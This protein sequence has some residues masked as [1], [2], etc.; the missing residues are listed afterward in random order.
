VGTYG[1]EACKWIESNLKERGR[2]V[3]LRWWQRY[4]IYRQLEHRAD[5]SLCWK[6]VVESTPRRSGKST[7][8]RAVALWRLAQGERLFEPEQLVVHTGRDLAIVREVLRKAWPWA[9]AR[10]G[11]ATKRGMTEPEV[12][13]GQCRWIARSKDS[14]T[15]YDACLA[16]VD[17]A[18]DVK[19][20]TIDDDLEPSMLE[21]E[22][23]QL[24]LTS[25]AHRR[26]TSL[27]RRRIG[28]ALAEDDGE[29]LLLLWGAPVDADISD[30]EVWR[31][32]SP[33]WSEDR[34]KM[35][36]AKYEKAVAGEDDPEFDDPDPMIGF[37][38]QYLNQWR[39]NEPRIA[40]NAIVTQDDWN[41][42]VAERPQTVPD[43][44]AVESW[45]AEGVC[46]A[47]AWKRPDGSVV[48]SVE[49]HPTLSA[50]VQS[51]AGKGLKKPVLVGASLAEDPI[52]LQNRLRATSQREATRTAVGGFI[53]T[54]AERA[55]FHDGSDVL[56]A[57]VIGLRISPGVDGPR[58]RSTGRADAIKA[59]GWCVQEA[60][61][62]SRMVL[63]SRFRS[64]S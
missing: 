50:A 59:V 47:S 56:T 31:A 52:W 16:L 13:H 14:L 22:S 5:G 55:F 63:P 57:Q 42:L 27:M 15:G 4:A 33:Y 38:C 11:W 29:T 51:V 25:T 62:G 8:L 61:K 17:E 37:A 35:I 9:E 44:V 45:V 36:A 1:P 19:P 53:R 30:P 28:A 21:R 12:S 32:A 6:W 46:V 10:D 39:V 60:A 54:L 64:A 2:P 23:P 24:L 40:G 41:D 49:D 58:I 43:S 48:V 34:R 18:W 3:R 20:S 7:R 26:A